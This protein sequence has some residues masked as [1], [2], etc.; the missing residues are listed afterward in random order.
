MPPQYGYTGIWQA[1]HCY[2][3][4]TALSQDRVRKLAG[5]D[6]RDPFSGKSY[7]EPPVPPS[8]NFVLA[9]AFLQLPLPHG[10]ALDRVTA[11]F[12]PFL[13]I[14]PLSG[15]IEGD[16][17]LSRIGLGSVEGRDS[18][19]KHPILEYLQ[20]ELNKRNPFHERITALGIKTGFIYR[21]RSA[22]AATYLKKMGNSHI[23]L[24]GDAAYVHTPM[25]GQD[26]KEMDVKARD[27][28]LIHCAER[29]RE[30]GY[31]VVGTTQ[32]FN[33]FVYWNQGWRRIVRNMV[34]VVLTRIP[35]F[36]KHL[37]MLISGLKN[38]G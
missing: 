2:C 33:Y 19:P 11:F 3:V 23:L 25:G 32:K 35:H 14:V 36:Q 29:R 22:L 1:I 27:G 10:I 21:T 6:F 7:N 15:T 8:L 9:D 20:K 34:L 24:V 30:I 16:K 4:A 5:I 28:I 13:F 12:D 18:L 17:I 38:R 37:A 31:D 26:A